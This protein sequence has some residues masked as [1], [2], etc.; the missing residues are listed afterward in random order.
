ME[1]KKKDTLRKKLKAVEN[2]MRRREDPEEAERYRKKERNKAKEAAFRKTHHSKEEV[3]NLEQKLRR[4]YVKFSEEK[5]SKK[6]TKSG[7][8]FKGFRFHLKSEKV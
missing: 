3:K 4:K 2:G 7:T 5:S 8:V 1:L 6:S